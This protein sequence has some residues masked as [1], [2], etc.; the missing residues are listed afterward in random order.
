MAP[1]GCQRGIREL[2]LFSRPELVVETTAAGLI[3]GDGRFGEGRRKGRICG[4]VIGVC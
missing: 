2:W 3:A 4:S 1:S